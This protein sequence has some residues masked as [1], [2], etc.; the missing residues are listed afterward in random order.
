MLI[1]KTKAKQTLGE[2]TQV[3]KHGL[4]VELSTEVKSTALD[5]RQ[6]TS[7]RRSRSQ[8][9]ME[10]FLHSLC[11]LFQVKMLLFRMAYKQKRKKKKE[12][13]G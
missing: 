12:I 6:S 4:K 13:P 3:H 10:G 1:A 9:Q 7:A 8:Q 2:E 5:K 11:V